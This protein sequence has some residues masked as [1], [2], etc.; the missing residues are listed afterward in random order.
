MKK[1][2][3]AVIVSGL[4]Y[5]IIHLSVGLWNEPQKII[6]N[7]II[8]YYA[9]LPAT[10]IYGDLSLQFKEENP[11]FF[12][13]KIWGFKQDN[14]KY[15]LK[16]SMGLSMMYMPFFLLS[17]GLTYCTSFPT[18]GY[19][20]LYAFGLIL[21]AFVYFILGLLLLRKFLLVYFNDFSVMITLLAI[22]LATNLSHYLVREPA[23]SHAFSFFLFASFLFLTQRWYINPSFRKALLLGLVL[24]LISLVRPTN[25]IIVVVFLMWDIRTIKD[26]LKIPSFLKLHY[27]HILIMLLP[28]ALVWLPQL[29]YWHYITG[30]WIHYS[31]NNEGFFFLKPKILRVLIGFRKG[32][33]LY[34]P[35]MII[36]VIGLAS[37]WKTH[38]KLFWN[39]SLFFILNVYIIASWWCWWFGGS[40]GH[41]AFIDSYPLMAI[42]I[43]AWIQNYSGQRILRKISIVSFLL[44][45]MFHN[46]FQNIK[47]LNNSIHY[48]SM[49]RL[50]YFE[51]I[52]KTNPTVLYYSLLIPPDYENALLGLPERNFIPQENNHDDN[53]QMNMVP[54]FEELHNQ[55]FEDDAVGNIMDMANFVTNE[56]ARTGKSSYLLNTQQVYRPEFTFNQSDLV[57]SG[58][59]WISAEVWFYPLQTL[60]DKTLGIVT[61]FE[62]QNGVFQYD[63][64]FFA[65]SELQYDSWNVCRAMIKIP[66]QQT[67]LDVFKCYIWNVDGKASGYIDDFRITGIHS[68]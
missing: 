64:R 2:L 37:L 27:K 68:K 11:E 46:L 16:M 38:R 31:Y 49:T 43:A 21:A 22:A 10:F 50:A 45:F 56:Q 14:G 62:N 23:M 36:A 55:N 51:T 7:D 19:S 32:W 67:V 39:T 48:D 13:D 6:A 1:S 4:I 61:S 65:P 5:L 18:D 53:E 41:R 17:H 33:L 54:V 15:V 30:S 42:P 47:Y 34:T 44:I 66:Q 3:F 52:D 12:A 63:V 8:D 40:Y 9:Y 25:I 58:Y 28:F 24:G 60:S 35:V 29:I 59:N 20:P 26:I 57:E